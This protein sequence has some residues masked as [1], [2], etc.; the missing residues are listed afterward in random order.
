MILLVVVVGEEK[1][2]K[3]GRVGRGGEAMK[4]GGK[5]RRERRSFNKRASC[6]AKHCF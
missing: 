2:A 3:F 5:R 4:I 6:G 1:E